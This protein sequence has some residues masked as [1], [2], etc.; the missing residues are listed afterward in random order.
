[1]RIYGRV[2]F[3][4]KISPKYAQGLTDDFVRNNN[5]EVLALRMVYTAGFAIPTYQLIMTSTN[6]DYLEAF[7]EGNTVTLTIGSLDSNDVNTI[8]CETI[9]KSIKSASSEGG[10][11]VLNWGGVLL[12]NNLSSSFLKSKGDAVY[13]GTATEIIKKAWKDITNNDIDMQGEPSSDEIR[14]F[15]RRQNQTANNFLVDVFLHLDRR[16]SFPLATIDEEGKLRIRDF[17]MLKDGAPAAT[18]VPAGKG[19]KMANEY[20]YLGQPNTVSYKTYTNRA[21]GY[22]QISGRNAE[23]GKIAIIGSGGGKAGATSY[24]KKSGNVVTPWGLQKLAITSANEIN[25]V[26]MRKGLSTTA[27]INSEN[28]A[29]F[30][31]IAQHN[32]N[33]LINMSSIQTTVRIEDKYLKNLHVLDIVKLKTGEANDPNSG[34]Y[35]IEAIEQGFVKGTGFTNILYLCRDNINDVEKYN[36]NPYER[37]A[38]GLIDID[39]QTKADITGRVAA[40]RKGIAMVKGLMDGTTTRE[41]EAHLVGM[42]AAALSNF[43]MFGHQIDIN[44]LKATTGSLKSVSETIFNK[45]I[46]M[47]VKDPMAS[48]LI[49]LG[50]G[51]AGMMNLLLGLLQGLFGAQLF[52]SFEGLLSDLKYFFDFLNNYKITV[53]QAERIMQPNYVEY[54]TKG[55]WTFTESPDGE[56]IASIVRDS[57]DVRSR[58]VAVTSEEKSMIVD[59]VVNQ[60]KAVIPPTVD[61]PIKEVV[62]DDSEAIK[63]TEQIKSD[64][65]DVIVEDLVDRGYIYDADVVNQ[66]ESTGTGTSTKITTANGNKISA[67]EAKSVMVSSVQ[68]KQMLMGTMPFD[69]TSAGKIREIV[70]NTVY[71]RHWGTFITEN[72]LASFNINRGFVDKY[73]SINCTKMLSVLGGKRIYVALPAFEERVDFYINSEK[74][75]MGT[76]YY[77]SLGYKD[78]QGYDIPYIIYYTPDS[79]NSSSVSVELR[80]G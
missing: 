28:P 29:D 53:N 12:K 44:N 35:I 79:Y 31:S 26:D 71:V 72:E 64:I 3:D 10:I 74:V 36:A 27:L 19:T 24:V 75:T 14:R 18:L 5:I 23:T 51:D 46:R 39:A 69:S 78:S 68:M 63:P 45:F 41:W 13:T 47:F 54:F 9:G 2:Q 16:P 48:L 62:I 76:L 21:C 32:K 15:Y 22:S 1:M 6:R 11:F 4:V 56:L 65:V 67:L 43:Y 33:N 58:S 70:G 80:R 20:P 8:E 34:L 50:L 49:N 60:I 66:A 61:I 73:K 25:M 7:N 37:L 42:R 57:S 40:S 59:S 38:R 55:T 52:S 77:S 30:H 17:S